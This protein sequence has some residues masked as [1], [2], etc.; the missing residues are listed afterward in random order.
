M[1]VLVLDGN[2]NQA[3]TSVRSLSRAGHAVVV[4][5]SSSWSK[6]GWSRYCC[7]TFIYPPPE[8]DMEAFVRRIA[9]EVARHPGTIVLPMTEFTTLPLSLRRETIFAAGGRLVLPPHATVLRAF[10]KQQT[11]RLAESLGIAVPHTVHISDIIE[12]RETAEKVSYPVVL[13]PRASEEVS[14]AG[15]VTGTGRPLYARDTKEFL[16]AYDSLRKRCSQ[17]LSQEFV[18]GAGCGYFALMREGE[19]RAEFAHRR[20][21]DVRPTGSGSSL[22]VSVKPDPRLREAGLAIL[23][24]LKWHGVAMVEFRV[25]PDG[26]VVFLEVNGRFWLSLA[27]AV[28]SGV[29][30]PALLVEMAARGDIDTPPVYRVGV[31]C[32]W[33][34]GDARHLI[35][36]WLGPPRGYPGKFPKRLET[37]WSFLAPVPGTFHDNLEWCDPLPAVGDGV[38]YALRCLR[39]FTKRKSKAKK[40]AHAERGYSHP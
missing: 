17:V 30:F 26:T 36:V 25:R 2:E 32:R 24:A 5:A 35:E 23:H 37:L 33:L 31:R 4:G 6:A 10:D 39:L 11:T 12:A 21:R 14:S 27:L 16:I 7:G 9:Q 22:R 38:D 40:N 18:E 3:V 29:D 19:L 13:K 28:H 34:L 1:R 20:L 8:L 15:E